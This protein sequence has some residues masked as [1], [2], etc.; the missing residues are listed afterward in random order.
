[1]PIPTPKLLFFGTFVFSASFL[2]TACDKAPVIPEPETNY[3]LFVNNEVD[4]ISAHYRVFISDAEGDLLAYRE[5]DGPDTAII[6]VPGKK[7]SELLSV[8]VL[9]EVVTQGGTGR[10][11]TLN[12]QTYTQ[13]PSGQTLN[14]RNSSFHQNTDLKIQFTGVISLDTIVVPDGLQFVRA[15]PENNYYGQFRVKNTGDIWIRVKVNGESDW[16]FWHFRNI[17]G[18][19]LTTSLDVTLMPIIFAKP[20]KM[21][22]PFSSAWAYNIDGVIDQ[23]ALHFLP[24]GITIIPPG[25]AIPTFG[26]LDVYEPVNNPEFFPEPKPYSSFR[27]RFSGEESSPNGYIYYCDYFSSE[28][29]AT[30]PAISFD[31]E[32]TTLSD[33]RL[34][35][36]RC[37]GNFDALA[38]SRAITIGHTTYEWDSYHP[39]IAGA[40]VTSRLPDLPPQ[41]QQYYP[42]LKNYPFSQN[43]LVRAE[44]YEKLNDYEAVRIQ[45]MEFNSPVWQTINGYLGRGEIY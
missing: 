36:A 13:T 10:D 45:R 35:A 20:S 15:R 19:T 3:T 14:L 12:I 1:M 32:P 17:S 26:L 40:I 31:L 38:F 27:I 39:A 33:N 21:T 7:E 25:G 6:Q 11:T 9:R 44:A 4:V 43:V 2:I 28:L 42:G 34:A 37:I 16:R 30:L 24:L 23:N 29:P 8:S 18:P 22:L 5:I 41:L